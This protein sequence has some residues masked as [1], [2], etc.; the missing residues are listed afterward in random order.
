[1]K[2]VAVIALA[3]SLLTMQACQHEQRGPGQEVVGMVLNPGVRLQTAQNMIVNASDLAGGRYRFVFGP[4]IAEP[5]GSFEEEDI[6]A[7][8]GVAPSIT[9][10]KKV[11]MSAL[12]A[13]PRADGPSASTMAVFS[14]TGA[15]AQPQGV[16]VAEEDVEVF[17]VQSGLS[18][19]WGVMPKAKS[20]RVYVGG[21]G[22]KFMLYVL[23]PTNP[24]ELTVEHIVLVDPINSDRARIYHLDEHGDP[25]GNPA[26]LTAGHLYLRVNLDGSFTEINAVPT[27]IQAVVDYAK[28]QARAAGVWP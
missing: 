20:R 3:L 24:G 2:Y 9:S 28:A 6:V 27:D 26:I 15:V 25:V 11:K 1:M 23:P 18:L 21:D 8:G 14:T 7:S 17:E 13:A 4:Y 10:S 22:T 16:Q 5:K 12:G 19:F